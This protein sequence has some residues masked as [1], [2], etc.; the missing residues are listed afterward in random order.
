[1]S[2]PLPLPAIEPC[3]YCG[4]KFQGRWDMSVW[5]LRSGQVGCPCGYSSKQYET[6]RDAINAHNRVARAAQAAAND[7]LT[8]RN[9]RCLSCGHSGSV[10]E[11]EFGCRI[12]GKRKEFT[13]TCKRWKKGA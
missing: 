13:D 8:P 12:T 2:K 7:P 4:H 10:S 1:V 9:K 5:R 3:P 6:N 11:M